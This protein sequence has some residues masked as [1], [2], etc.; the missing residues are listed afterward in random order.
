MEVSRISIEFIVSILPNISGKLWRLL[1][2]EIFISLRQANFKGG[3]LLSLM[4]P[5]AF[6]NSSLF[7]NPIEL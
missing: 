7:K 2:C 5:L 1:Q 3:K 4:Q 6:K